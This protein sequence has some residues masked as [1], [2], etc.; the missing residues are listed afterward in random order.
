MMNRSRGFTLIELMITLVIVAILA[1]I[2]VPSYRAFIL[3]SHRVEATAAL[4]K[5]AAAEE[6][7]Y[8]Q[9]N[10]YTTELTALDSATPPGLGVVDHDAG[11]AGVQTEN[12]WYTVAVTAADATGF[13]LTGAAIGDQLKDADCKNFGLTS[14]GVKTAST[15]KCWKK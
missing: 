13:T 11:V 1:S 12:S 9:H 2:A 6:K 4:L 3:R 14:A 15:D 5:I 10:T 7:F 8:L